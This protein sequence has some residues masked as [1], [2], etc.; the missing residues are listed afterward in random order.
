[1]ESSALNPPL[2]YFSFFYHLRNLWK[3]FTKM[4]D[5]MIFPMTTLKIIDIYISIPQAQ[6]LQAEA[7]E[8]TA[9]SFFV[10]I[11][12]GLN[13]IIHQW[14]PLVPEHC[15]LGLPRKKTSWKKNVY[16]YIYQQVTDQP[17]FVSCHMCF[18][19]QH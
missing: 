17:R 18:L 19:G 2:T 5:L 4:R 14:L 7:L 8:G 3:S 9:R 13:P 15:I 12:Q 1:M 11:H 16:I 6:M 10:T